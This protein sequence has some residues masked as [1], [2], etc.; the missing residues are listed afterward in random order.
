MAVTKKDFE[1][2]N[3]AYDLPNLSN[4]YRKNLGLGLG[5]N[6][7][8]HLKNE[9]H[10]QQIQQYNQEQLHHNIMMATTPDY[11][12]VPVQQ[13]TDTSTIG[14]QLQEVSNGTI[15]TVGVGSPNRVIRIC[16][17][18]ETLSDEIT[19]AIAEFKLK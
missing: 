1:A 19:A 13:R 6:Q 16:P 7:M 18:E 12:Q 11:V 8:Q 14:I 4:M 15:I 3:S 2:Q 5:P 9:L 10:Q 17:K